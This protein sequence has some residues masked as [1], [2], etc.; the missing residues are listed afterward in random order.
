MTTISMPLP[1]KINIDSD[2]QI[3]FKDI[4]TRY[5]DGYTEIAPDGLNSARETWD[6][7]WAPLTQSEYNTVKTA[8]LSVGTWGTILWTP[9][10]DTVQK[11]FRIKSKTSLRRTRIAHRQYKVSITVEQIFDI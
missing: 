11:K 3:D 7:N 8:L 2:L 4:S 6:I 5:G 1:G 10:D 9:C